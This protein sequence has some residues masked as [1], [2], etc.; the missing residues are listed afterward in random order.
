MTTSPDAP[1]RAD[2]ARRI[3]LRRAA[4]RRAR[5]HQA[6]ARRSVLLLGV[7]TPPTLER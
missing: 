7:G 3:A 6:V 4:L 5:A 2:D 1:F